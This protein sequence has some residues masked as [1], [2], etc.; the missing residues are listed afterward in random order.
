M[1]S[2]KMILF[3]PLSPPAFRRLLFI[4]WIVMAA[5]PGVL[6][7]HGVPMKP[8]EFKEALR[9]PILSAPT[10][11]TADGSIDY[12]GMKKVMERAL[13]YGCKVITLTSGNNRYDRLSYQE[14]KNLTRLMVD[15]GQ[16]RAITI[17]A[18]YKTWSIDTVI[19]YVRY[20]ES[21]GASAVQV[22]CPEGFMQDSSIGSIRAFY[23]QVA[24]QT[25]L[26][27][28]LHGYYSAALLKALITIPSVVALKED[29]ADLNYY[30]QRQIVFGDRL[31]IFAGGS[32]SRYLFGYAYGSPAYFSTLYSYAP[33]IGRQY[34]NAIQAKDLKKA[35]AIANHY[36]IPFMKR[37][38]FPFWTAAI[39]YLGGSQR[40]IRFKKGDKQGAETLSD[41]ELMQMQAFVDSLGLKADTS[42]FKAMT[43]EGI[44][45]P[46]DGR[47]GG[48]AGGNVENHILVTGGTQWN[49]EK[50]AKHYLSSTAVFASGRWQPGP[51]LPR[52]LAYAM[53]GSDAE[54]MYLAGGV[55]SGLTL[56]K[57]AYHL[58]RLSQGWQPL[59][60]LPEGIA[61]GAGAA[62]NGKFYIAC[63]TGA[64]GNSNGMWVLD[65][66]NTTAGWKKCASLPGVAR[67][68]PALVAC[69]EYLYLL[70]GLERTAPLTPL[71]D[72]YRYDPSSD[73]WI[74]LAD[75]PLA[76][77]AWV[78]K[79][80]GP[81]HIM[82]TGRAFGQ[83]D[84]GI[85]ILDIEK[86]S[87][88][89]IGENTSPATTAPLVQADSG[90]WW[91]I[92]GE[93]DANKNRSSK[94]SVITLQKQ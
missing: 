62:L 74:R 71:K 12:A 59:P 2:L 10:A 17:A 67:T 91:L 83:I 19:A 70:G 65:T 66:R 34:W 36:D 82:L 41:D 9:G 18:T 76:S 78:G 86:M 29:V 39:A 50:T 4:A 30:V 6:A 77:Y 51:A 26:G 28:V 69:G 90:V 52:G 94:V 42:H 8:A 89:K 31:A 7:Q 81:G 22:D 3:L 1:A 61:Y 40:Y 46:A 57:T 88:N 73:Q 75:L 49:E 20:A 33:W 43:H 58:H 21:I 92:G 60:A 80:T 24:A 16:G 5:A 63:G 13:D 32:D 85:W 37:W 47:R 93:P 25:H 23:S 87:L 54:G 64:R 48:H 38:S 14:I 35:V 72:A 45:L 15:A 56:L 79:Q 68:F 11:F 27:I 53:Y 55:D 84:K 44:P